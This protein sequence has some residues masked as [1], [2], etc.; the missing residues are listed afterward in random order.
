MQFLFHEMI[1]V[2]SMKQTEQSCGQVT[3]VA[4]VG[5]KMKA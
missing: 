1:A 5:E 2:Q 3:V 4:Q